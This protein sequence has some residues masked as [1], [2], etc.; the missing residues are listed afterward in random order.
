[1]PTLKTHKGAKRRI[2][3]TGTG[4]LR[5][6]KSGRRHLLTGK[7]ASKMRKLRRPTAVSSVVEAKIKSLLPY[8]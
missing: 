2:K 3:V 8:R 4:K 7:R 5:H 6:F 1:M